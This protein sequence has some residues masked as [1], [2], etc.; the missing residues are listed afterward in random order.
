MFCHDASPPALLT[1]NHYLIQ[2]EG[3]SKRESS[4]D[5]TIMENTRMEMDNIEVQIDFQQYCI[6]VPTDWSRVGLL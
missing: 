5:Y 1:Q 4:N 2:T 3:N 6:S